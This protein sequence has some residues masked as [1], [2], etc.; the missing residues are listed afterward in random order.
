ME[1]INYNKLKEIDLKDF[2][3]SM[4]KIEKLYKRS[5]SNVFYKV[6]FAF[7]AYLYKENRLD[8]LEFFENEYTK[9]ELKDIWRKYKKDIEDLASDYIIDVFIAGVLFSEDNKFTGID[10]Q[11]TPEGVCELANNILNIQK[12]DIVL[13]LGSGAGNY[14]IYTAFNTEAEEFYGIELNKDSVVISQIR[15]Y[16]TAKNIKIFNNTIFNEEDKNK[17]ADKVFSNFPLGKRFSDI[18]RE[19]YK[20]PELKDFFKKQ[21]KLIS[22][23]WAFIMGGYLNLTQNGKACIVTSNASLWNEVDKNVREEVLEMGIIEG[24]ISLGEKILNNTRTSVSLIVLSNGNKEVKMID[25]SEVFT[26]GRRQNFLEKK[27]IKKIIKAYNSDEKTEISRKVDFDEIKN[28]DYILSPQR[29]MRKESQI[30]NTVKLDEVVKTIQRGAAI[31]SSKLNELA[32][33]EDTGIYYLH[34]KDI[35][36]GL[37]NHDLQR[38]KELDRNLE[39]Y[40]LNN[41]DLIFTKMSPFKVALAKVREGQKI[42]ASG[43]MYILEIDKSKIVP[44]YLEAYLQS[45]KG[46]AEINRLSKG[47]SF[48]MINVSDLKKI[49]IPIFDKDK[50]KKISHEYSILKQELIKLSNEIDEKTRKKHKLF[51]DLVDIV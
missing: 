33:T 32:T 4:I 31:S 36:E 15:S 48:S 8:D 3:I 39:R 12:D 6:V 1:R 17:R 23:D 50:Q 14:I 2:E 20:V 28:H 18:K 27:D 34:L 13:D 29:Y 51:D 22:G 42:V 21:D 44:E 24:I 10:E 43:N 7:L 45:D 19:I 11:S 35:N 38:L 16:F 25:A 26:E 37:I 40:I 30:K 5:L 49:N 41:D 46:I 47:S 9:N